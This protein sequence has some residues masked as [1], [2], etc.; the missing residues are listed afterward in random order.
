MS[1]RELAGAQI[2]STKARFKTGDILFAKIRPS[3]D[4]K[5]VAYVFQT[6]DNAIASTEFLVLRPHNPAD[7]PF[8]FT[9]LRADYFTEQVMTACGGDTGRQRIRP[10]QLLDLQIRWPED[11]VRANIAKTCARQFEALARAFELREQA[12]RAA[13]DAIGP[14]KFQT[15]KARRKPTKG[16][17]RSEKRPRVAA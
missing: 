2:G 7:A 12:L 11:N 13:E 9:A 15:A 6:F 4:N 3:I 1:H 5:K 14:T 16:V 10:E 17:Q 8:I